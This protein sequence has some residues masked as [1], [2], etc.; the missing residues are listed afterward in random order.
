[1]GWNDNQALRHICTAVLDRATYT[2][3]T[4]IFKYGLYIIRV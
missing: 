3:S 2:N 4:V 1:M